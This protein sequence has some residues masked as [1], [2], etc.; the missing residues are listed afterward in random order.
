MNQF[1]SLL[2]TGLLYGQITFAQYNYPPTKTVDSSDTYWGRSIPDPY[3]WLENL[4]SPEVLNWFK[5]QAE[6]TNKQL[7]KISG[8]DRLIQ[9][10][11]D[12]DKIVSVNY[13]PISKAGGKYF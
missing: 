8:Q 4:K 6:Y 5:T 10:L 9:E 7:E 13:S 11:K 2:I 1:L 12:L 3:R